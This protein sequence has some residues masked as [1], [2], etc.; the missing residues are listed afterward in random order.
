MTDEVLVTLYGSTDY[1]GNVWVGLLM[2]WVLI[3]G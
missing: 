1:M 2:G 3:D